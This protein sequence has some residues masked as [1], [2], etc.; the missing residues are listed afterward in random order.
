MWDRLCI[1]T[2]LKS[3]SSPRMMFVVTAF[4]WI[5]S[6]AFL[7]ILYYLNLVGFHYSL[8]PPFLNSE[9]KLNCKPVLCVKGAALRRDIAGLKA[10][11]SPSG[12]VILTDGQD[13]FQPQYS[14]QLHHYQFEDVAEC[15][16]RLSSLRQNKSQLVNIAFVGDSIIRYQFQ[17]FLRVSQIHISYSSH[18]SSLPYD[19]PTKK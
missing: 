17:S 14:C 9:N 10:F 6:A 8:V 15:L 13:P 16:D 3:C 1:T 12:R 11:A 19:C 7:A 18:Y 2:I 4:F 5:K